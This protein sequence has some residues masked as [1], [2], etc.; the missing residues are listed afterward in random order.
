MYVVAY[1]GYNFDIPDIWELR[2][3]EPYTV[4]ELEKLNNDWS[5]YKLAK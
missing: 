2:V 5:L 1:K 3:F 4:Y